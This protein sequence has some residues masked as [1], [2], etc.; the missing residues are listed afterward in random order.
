MELELRATGFCGGRKTGE[1]G[2]KSSE[3][4][5]NQQQTQATYDTGPESNPGHICGRR[6]PSPL[7]YPCNQNKNA[8]VKEIT[9]LKHQAGSTVRPFG[10][11]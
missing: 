6:A 5:E 7:H 2:E 9:T 4:G 10:E 3:Q 8:A 11:S 1:P